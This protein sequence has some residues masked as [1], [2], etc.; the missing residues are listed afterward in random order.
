MND[1]FKTQDPDLFPRLTFNCQAVFETLT[2]FLVSDCQQVKTSFWKGVNFYHTK[3]PSLV[4]N[5]NPDPN[6]N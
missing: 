3:P 1:V 6:K 2:K 4:G 5:P